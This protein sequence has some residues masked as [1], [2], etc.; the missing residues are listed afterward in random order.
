HADIR[1]LMSACQVLH[2]SWS[3]RSARDNSEQP[4]SVLVSQLR[5]EIDQLWG[6]G[7]A[8]RLTT[9][10]PLQAFSRRYFESGSPLQTFAHEWQAVSAATPALSD[11]PHP[12]AQPLPPMDAAQGLPVLTLAQWQAFVRRPVAAFFRQRLGVDLRQ[13]R[14]ELPDEERFGLSGLDLYGLLDEAL[15]HGL[16]ELGTDTL[17]THVRATL[18]RWRLAGELPLAGVGQLAA[19]RLGSELHRLLA[20]AI[21]V[22]QAWPE[23]APHLAI[24]ALHPA[25]RLQDSL[26]GLRRRST[27]PL[28]GEPGAHTAWIVLRASR[29]AELSDA[30]QVRPQ[31]E[32]LLGVWLG[33]LAANASGLPLW[34]V[35][36]GRGALLHSPP[37]PQAQAQ[38]QLNALLEVWAEGMRWPL[39]LPPRIA[40][41]WLQRPEISPALVDLY[42]GDGFESAGVAADDPALQRTYPT[43]AELMAG[44]H[45]ERLAPLVFGPLLAWTAQLHGQALADAQEALA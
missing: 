33:Q 1:A 17:P 21:E 30:G 4:P 15:Q 28:T 12:S 42:E 32:K 37:L 23:P 35:V 44:G 8:Q 36:V 31:P 5:D 24:D 14:T 27:H 41:A 45:L 43:L 3:G 6:T 9:V 11:A 7:S 22:Q 2:V 13:E 19:E 16:G 18:Q 38:A 25:V 29:V 34:A 10:H 40:L 20:Q 26:E 39:P